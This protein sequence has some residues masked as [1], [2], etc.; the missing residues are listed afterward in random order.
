MVARYSEFKKV[1]EAEPVCPM[2]EQQVPPM[3]VK[4]SDDSQA[5]FKALV[6]LMKE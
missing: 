2:C 5:E 4:I 6:S 1:L 3:S